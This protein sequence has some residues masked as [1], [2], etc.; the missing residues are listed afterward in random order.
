MD[1]YRKLLYI[2]CA[3]LKWLGAQELQESIVLFTARP[4]Q[5]RQIT[6]LYSLGILT[7]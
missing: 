3:I 7:S 2:A 1:E 6:M 5:K 4:I